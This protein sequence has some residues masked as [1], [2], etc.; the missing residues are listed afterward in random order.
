M[1][2]A[3]LPFVIVVALVPA[4]AVF[5][6]EPAVTLSTLLRDM[7]DLERLTRLPNPAYTT[8]QFSSYDRRATSPEVPTDENWFANNDRGNHLRTETRNGAPEHVMVDMQGPGAVVRFW[9][10][11]PEDAGIVRVYLDGAED[12]AIEMPLTEFLGGKNALT[13]EPIGGT[14]SRGWN[15]YLPIPFSSGCKITASEPNFYYIVDLRQYEDG[16]PV[17]TFDPAKRAVYEPEIAFVASLLEQPFSASA[18]RDQ[19]LNGTHLRMSLQP[20]AT[21]SIARLEGPRAIRGINLTVQAEDIPAALRGVLLQIRFDWMNRP[22]VE[23]P[24]GDFFGTA[25][26]ANTYAGLPCGVLENGTLYSH[27]VMPFATRAD[28]TLVNTTG[29]AVQLD[30]QIDSAPREWTDDSLYFFAQ[31]RAA[32]DIPTQ[33]RQDWNFV[34]IKGKGRFVGDM[35]H[36]ANPVKGWWGEGDEKIY[37]DGEAFPSFFGTG[38]EDYFGYAWSSNEPFTHAYHNQPRSDGPGNYGHSCVNRFHILDDI[39]FS[40]SLR[41]DMEI[42]HWT[43]TT[44]SQAAT[45][46][47]YATGDSSHNRERPAESDLRVP[48]I[49]AL[50]A[51]KRVEG[52]LEAE[53]MKVV[54][55]SGGKVQVQ[56]SGDWPWSGA[57]QQWWMNAKA[58]D[59]LELA[60]DVKEAGKYKILGVFTKAADY[61]IC[62]I[63]INDGEVTM[64]DGYNEGVIVTPEIALGTM[65]LPAGANTLK[66]EITGTNDAAHPPSHMVGVDYLRLEAAE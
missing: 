55:K 31:W 8:I 22:A 18:R 12:P 47:W 24:L 64:F 29:A 42:W 51:P 46:Y 33:P 7:T 21:T 34:E 59:M 20:G 30:A 14:R 3:L 48:E 60:F 25:P 43:D 36:I 65:E 5:A 27:W 54:S 4:I 38:S 41:F 19:M 45:T 35:L 57:K 16:T 13:P 11:N 28:V 2:R 40:K 58:G 6:D 63:R 50:P 23:V 49:A 44:V 26:G 52:A 62:A 53:D 9:S 32:F 37:V 61:G 66:I 1:R 17:E 10:A 56:E 15:S 39:L